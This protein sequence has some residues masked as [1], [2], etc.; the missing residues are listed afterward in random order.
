MRLLAVQPY[1]KVHRQIVDAEIICREEERRIYLYH[2][3]LITKH[4]VFCNKDISDLSYRRIGDEGGWLYVH[5]SRGI[6]SYN[7]PSSPESFIKAFR[8]H[9]K[10]DYF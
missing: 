6:F 4:R 1:I 9:I 10:K 2:D 8:V 3:R 7:V 5:T